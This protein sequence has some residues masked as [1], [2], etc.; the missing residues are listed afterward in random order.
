MHAGGWA[1]RHRSAN[2][3]SPTPPARQSHTQRR[4]ND[5]S[6]HAERVK[7]HVDVLI[8]LAD[9]Q[10]GAGATA[11]G[12]TD[13]RESFKPACC[14]VTDRRWP[15]LAIVGRSLALRTRCRTLLYSA[16]TGAM[17]RPM[18]SIVHDG[19]SSSIMANRWQ[20]LWSLSMTQVLSYVAHH[21]QAGMTS[22]RS[23]RGWPA[24]RSRLHL[25]C[26]WRK[27]AGSSCRSG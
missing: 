13:G 15:L 19:S 2:P 5:R 26:E 24:P 11:T 4:V 1:Y 23:S 7:H 22:P 18:I 16:R 20:M 17:Y 25:R 9:M 3:H 21:H 8:A 27:P 10:H 6:G 12:R 14:A